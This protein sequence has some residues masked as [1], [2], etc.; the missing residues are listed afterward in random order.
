MRVAVA[1]PCTDRKRGGHPAPSARLRSV[2]AALPVDERAAQ[3]VDR[4]LRER[5]LGSPPPLSEL[6]VGP[7][8]TASM[9]LVAGVAEALDGCVDGFVIS[10][11]LGLQRLDQQG[12][13]WPRYSAT[14][15]S[16]HLDSVVA[17]RRFQDQS[18]STWWSTLGQ[19]APLGGT[20][21]AEVASSYDAVL[22]VAS[23]RYLRAVARDLAAAACS[24]LKVVAF[25]A[26][27]PR[28]SDVDPWLVRI[29][30]RARSVVAASDARASAD[31]VAFVARH[32]G[33]D[34]L[35][36]AAARDFVEHTLAG[37]TAPRRPRGTTAQPE[38]VRAFI[39][40]SLRADPD[41]RKGPLLRRWRDGG[42][43]FEQK[44]FGAIYEDVVHDLRV[45][46]APDTRGVPD[47]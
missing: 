36:I 38:E 34:L 39:E 37:R 27:A 29:D 30:A 43:A 16:G 33:E 32:L 26:S 15:A 46:R 28:L 7:G 40:A 6:Y 25:A 42:R 31:F 9:Q 12:V 13:G 11:G 4:L 44:R 41:M 10:A 22:V 14:F 21:F 17:D 8:W 23:A 47:A 19:S 35:D 1:V 24:G 18:A 5:E 3:W 20:T 2:P 45:A